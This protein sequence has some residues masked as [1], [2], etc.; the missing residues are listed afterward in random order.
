MVAYLAS[1]DAWN[2]NGQLFHVAGGSVGLAHHP[3]PLRTLWKPGMWTLDELEQQVP[4]QLMAGIPNPAPPPPDLKIPGRPAEK[5][6]DG[7]TAGGAA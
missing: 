4:A 2:I 3:T 5:Q 6:A 7:A 1:D